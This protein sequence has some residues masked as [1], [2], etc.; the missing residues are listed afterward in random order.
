MDLQSKFKDATAAATTLKVRPDNHTLL[1]LYA[2]YKQATAGNVEG[3]R[4]GFTDLAGRAKYDAW[5][6]IQGTTKEEAMRLYISLVDS[7]KR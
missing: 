4:P 5:A 2:Y 1:K 6:K 7:L 3:G